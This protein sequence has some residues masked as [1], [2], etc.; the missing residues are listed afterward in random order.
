MVWARPALARTGGGSTMLGKL[1]KQDRVSCTVTHEGSRGRARAPWVR[2]FSLCLGTSG[3]I[4][5]RR[6]LIG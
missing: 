2:A 1:Q 3:E 4:P 5:V 6:G